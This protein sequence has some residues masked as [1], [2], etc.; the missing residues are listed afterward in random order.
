MSDSKKVEENIEQKVE[1]GPEDKVITPEKKETKPK[2]SGPPVA[3]LVA[4]LLRT[5]ATEEND[6]SLDNPYHLNRLKD[7]DKIWH[8]KES[9]MHVLSSNVSTP[10]ETQRLLQHNL[11]PF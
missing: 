2:Y 4:S 10:A 5:I 7:S 1:N 6:V 9:S 3:R 11:Q 8:S